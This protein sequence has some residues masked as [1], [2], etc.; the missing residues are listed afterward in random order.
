MREEREERKVEK[1]RKEELSYL[2]WTDESI[3]RADERG[4]NK[5]E[6]GKSILTDEQRMELENLRKLCPSERRESWTRF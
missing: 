4:T 2:V 6:P 1:K 5:N 3:E